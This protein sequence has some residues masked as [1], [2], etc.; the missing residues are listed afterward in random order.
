MS[1]AIEARRNGKAVTV[2]GDCPD[3][4]GEASENG[5]LPL[6]PS[7][8]GNARGGFLWV[9]SVCIMTRR[10]PAS[11]RSPALLAC[12]LVGLIRLRIR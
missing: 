9:L 8:R 2:H 6:G 1:L 3:F 10:T 5:T 12:G 11:A 4:R 7:G